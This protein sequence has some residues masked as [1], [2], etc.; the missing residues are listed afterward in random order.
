M[1]RLIPPLGSVGKTVTHEMETLVSLNPSNKIRL[2]IYVFIIIVVAKEKGCRSATFA[3]NIFALWGVSRLLLLW[4]ICTHCK[5]KCHPSSDFADFAV[6]VLIPS[7]FSRIDS[8][9]NPATLKKTA[10]VQV[11]AVIDAECI[12]TVL[13]VTVQRRRRDTPALRSIGSGW[14]PGGI[15]SRSTVTENCVFVYIEL[16]Q[17]VFQLHFDKDW[18]THRE[19]MITNKSFL[20]F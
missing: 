15:V 18:N 8:I 10:L 4:N 5:C 2:F 3:E 19:D 17:S 14:F 13:D 11:R 20:P 7:I 9:L 16:L 12:Q 6:R 1:L